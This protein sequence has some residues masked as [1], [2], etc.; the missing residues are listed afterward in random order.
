MN[1]TIDPRLNEIIDCLYRVASKAIVINKGKLLLVQEEQGWYGVPGGGIDHGQ[2][3]RESLVREIFE[4]LGTK[5]SI[6]QIPEQPSFVGI[7]GAFSGIPRVTIYYRVEITD[8][9]FDNASELSH[10]WVTA[11]ELKDIEL[12]PNIAV[13]RNELLKLLAD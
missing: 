12:G 5:I 11:D 1:D 10:R 3:L 13:S 9:E 7:G 4:E 6:E 8:T 2:D